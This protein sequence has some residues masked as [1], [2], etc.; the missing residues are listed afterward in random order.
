MQDEVARNIAR[1]LEIELT[2]AD[3]RRLA[4]GARAPGPAAATYE[5]YMRGKRYLFGESLSDFVSA[6]DWFEK[7]RAADPQFALAWAGLAD[8]YA[9]LAFQYQPEGDWYTRAKAMCEKALAL[10]P[11]LPE[12][13]Y[14]RAR[15]SWAPQ[16][17][18]D[19]AAAIRDLVPALRSRPN[20]EEA[21]VLLGNILHHVGLVEEAWTLYERA[22][23]VSPG[24]PRARSHIV[25]CLVALGRYQ[26]GLERSPLPRPSYSFLEY[27]RAM[28]HI[29]LG[30]LDEAEGILAEVTQRFPDDVLFPP[31]RGL[32]A[33]KRGNATEADRQIQIAAEEGKRYG[34]YHHLQ[35]DVACIHALLGRQEQALAWLT[36]AAHNGYPCAP[37]FTRD[38]FLELLQG[39]EGFE[40]LLGELRTE[41]Q[42][43]ARLYA[44]LQDVGDERP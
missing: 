7:A 38:D 2:P 19:H 31:L 41:S 33:A 24:H 25:M 10:D 22:E 42:G 39:T 6:L 44:Q 32:V 3:E 15:L 29:H 12:A 11:W 43:Y 21:Y 13:R 4:Q 28:C 26:E 20:L 8:A 30:R 35:Y 18:F 17:N 14:V 1:A 16:A 23:E 36:E 9:R 37:H 5:L 34:H 27:Q 40:R